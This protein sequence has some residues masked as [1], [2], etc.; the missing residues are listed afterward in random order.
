[1]N[2]AYADGSVHFI[3]ENIDTGNLS[4]EQSYVGPSMY[5][6]WGALGSK[7]GGEVNAYDPG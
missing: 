7:D 1:M 6:V 4:V 5:G 3:S 2:C